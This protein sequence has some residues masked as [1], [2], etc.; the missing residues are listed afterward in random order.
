MASAMISSQSLAPCCD[1]MA[2]RV[3]KIRG[4]LMQPDD[5]ISKLT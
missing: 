1:E 4:F 5:I 2:F 3:I